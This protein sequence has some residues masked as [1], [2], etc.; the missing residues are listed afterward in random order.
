MVGRKSLLLMGST[1]DTAGSIVTASIVI[2][3]FV[4]GDGAVVVVVS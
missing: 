1:V 4:V 2:G 3:F